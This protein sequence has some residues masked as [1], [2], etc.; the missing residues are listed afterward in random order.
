MSTALFDA[1][2]SEADSA[3]ASVSSNVDALV[4]VGE[5]SGNNSNNAASS[6]RGQDASKLLLA[7]RAVALHVSRLVEIVDS[8]IPAALP[9]HTPESEL[10][11]ELCAASVKS[12]REGTLHL[13]RCAKDQ[14]SC[15]LLLLVCLFSVSSFFASAIIPL[16]F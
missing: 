7:A 11:V 3:L 6:P 1:T 15:V 10:Q 12:I 4:A 5:S 16:I 9:V 8:H 13:L 14:V 2:L